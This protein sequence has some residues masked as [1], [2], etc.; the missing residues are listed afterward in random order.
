M[1]QRAQ[2]A[3]R[4]PGSHP[5]GL[6]RVQQPLGILVSMREALNDDAPTMLRFECGK[7]AER[8]PADV[9]GGILDKAQEQGLARVP[10][11]CEPATS[12]G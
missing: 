12:V 11:G 3:V 1:R 8:S 5:T 6:V 10:L 2:R 7:S 4:D 9:L